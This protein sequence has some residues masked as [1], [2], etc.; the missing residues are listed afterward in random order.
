[1]INIFYNKNGLD[2]ILIIK[3]TNNKK[4][5]NK[6]IETK[7]ENDYMLTFLDGEIDTISIK[8]VSNKIHINEGYLNATPEIIN[9]VKQETNI[10]ISIFN[11][12]N[13]VIGKITKCEHLPNTHLHL[14]NVLINDNKTLQIVCG[15]QNARENLN[16]VVA[17]IG[18]IMP[19][20]IPITKG[21]L[22]GHESFGMLCSE[23]ELNNL[24]IQSSGILEINDD[25]L[26][27]KEYISHYNN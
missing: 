22:Q 6:N 27:G 24:E 21:K 23:K 4:S 7:K 16:V 12:M 5:T 2:D 1:M 26:V 20:G 17:M 18:T 15:A 19:N 14:C 9:F 13:Y 8:N 3:I 11:E 10:D 25:S